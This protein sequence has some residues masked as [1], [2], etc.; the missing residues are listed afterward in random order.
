MRF[1]Q[2]RVAIDRRGGTV[3]VENHIFDVLLSAHE[4]L[5]LLHW[6]QDHEEE[7]RTL[8][9]SG[10]NKGRWHAPEV[11]DERALAGTFRLQRRGKARDTAELDTSGLPRDFDVGH[12]G[13]T[14]PR[15]GN[16]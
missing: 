11:V 13:T 3:V 6:L 2:M 14:V 8:E 9:L 10:A 7:L 16:Q 4:A 12:E 15:G 1:G 5:V